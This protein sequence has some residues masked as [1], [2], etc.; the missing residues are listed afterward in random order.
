MCCA[1]PPPFP[2]HTGSP[3]APILAALISETMCVLFEVPHDVITQKV[4]IQVSFSSDACMY[5]PPHKHMHV[6]SSSYAYV[7]HDVITQKVPM[8]PMCPKPQ[9]LKKKSY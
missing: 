8:C 6:S 4:Q 7:S 3:V 5:P 9:A 2:M 1:P